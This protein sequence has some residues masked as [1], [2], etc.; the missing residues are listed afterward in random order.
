[1]SRPVS[2]TLAARA[3]QVLRGERTVLDAVSLQFEPGRFT[4]IVGPN[5]TGKS[6]LLAS[7][8]GLHA[9]HAGSV[10]LGDRPLADWSARARAQ[11]VGWLGQHADA[12]G[13]LDVRAVVGLGRLPWVGLFGTPTAD[14]EA[15]IDAAMRETDTQ[16]LA[17]RRLSALSGGERQRVLIARVLAGQTPVLLLDEPTTH[18]DAPHQRALLRTLQARAAQGATVVAVLH[19]LSLALMADQLVVLINGQI[20]AHGSPAEPGVRAAIE[21]AFGDAIQILDVTGPDGTVTVAV[22]RR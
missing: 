22:P 2:L 5:G 3:L 20:H 6:T 13:E 4:A 8:A 1:M 10:W 11:R 17:H 15:A 12:E 18:L 14:D 19:D 9:A 7:L 16:A 21:R